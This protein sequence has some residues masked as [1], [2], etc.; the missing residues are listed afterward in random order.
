MH[1]QSYA[2]GPYQA[3]GTFAG[4]HWH[5]ISCGDCACIIARKA[6]SNHS[7]AG[8]ARSR[9]RG[10]P[11]LLGCW[12]VPVLVP[13]SRAAAIVAGAEHSTL[14]APSRRVRRRELFGQ[15]FDQRLAFHARRADLH[16]EKLGASPASTGGSWP[17]STAQQAF[18][19]PH[20]D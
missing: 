8:Q 13:T 6:S 17:G 4:S 2:Q 20:S 19:V 14:P 11:L 9:L 7:G 15:D 1:G 12:L 10:G 16:F 3:T 5:S 18:R